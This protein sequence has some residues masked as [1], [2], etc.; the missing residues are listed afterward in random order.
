MKTKKL[1]KKLRLNKSTIASLDTHF[2][3]F[4]KGGL[5][6]PQASDPSYCEC[7]TGGGGGGGGPTEWC[8]LTVEASVC[9]CTENWPGGC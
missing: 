8:Y 1:N 3:E 4:A 6:D 2:L 9:I 7:G 5:L